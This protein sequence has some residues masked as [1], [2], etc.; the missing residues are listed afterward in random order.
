M[1]CGGEGRRERQND[2]G[3]V[4]GW[5]TTES[6]LSQP[7]CSDKRLQA[8]ASS[9]WEAVL[10]PLGGPF[11]WGRLSKRAGRRGGCDREAHELVVAHV[12]AKA[13]A[14]GW[15][16]GGAAKQVIRQDLRARL[17]HVSSA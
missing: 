13:R 10:H 8:N 9:C 7:G 12:M 6:E 14:C 4:G 16:G 1:P 2:A 3:V 15:V 17:S 11:Q 5:R